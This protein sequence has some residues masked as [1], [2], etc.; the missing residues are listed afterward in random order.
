MDIHQCEKVI[1]MSIG[2]EQGSYIINWSDLYSELN[3]WGVNNAMRER[4][5]R[6]R[7]VR[8]IDDGLGWTCLNVGPGYRIQ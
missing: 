4:E 6:R 8:Q 3:L 5:M 7:I 2:A 1:P